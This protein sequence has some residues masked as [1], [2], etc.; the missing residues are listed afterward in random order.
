M[1]VNRVLDLAQPFLARRDQIEDDERHAR[2]VV[3]E[4][5]AAGEKI[6][7]APIDVAALR[8]E[9][10]RRRGHHMLAHLRT[11]LYAAYQRPVYPRGLDGGMA[12]S[13]EGNERAT[14]EAKAR[15]PLR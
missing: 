4:D 1:A 11:E 12:L 8:H 6:V 9:R 10:A 7:V 13:V 15:L 5:Q 2:L 14:T 3:V